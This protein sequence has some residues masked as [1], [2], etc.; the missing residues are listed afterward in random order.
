VAGLDKIFQ[1]FVDFSNSSLSKQWPLVF[2]GGFFTF[3]ALN[4]LVKKIVVLISFGFFFYSSFSQKGE[5]NK[6][7]Q[8]YNENFVSLSGPSEKILSSI[9]FESVIVFDKRFDSVS[10]GF[11]KDN[12][13]LHRG[14]L[15]IKNGLAYA[16]QKFYSGL[17]D[18][19]EETGIELVCFV[20]KTFLSDFIYV[21]LNEDARLGSKK[22]DK[23]EFSGAVARLEFY[24]K[25]DKKYYPLYRFDSTI[26][27]VKKISKEGNE[28]LSSMFA[29]AARKLSTI[30]WEKIRSTG[31]ALNSE[32]VFSHYDA[33][34]AIPVL[35]EQPVKGVY[36]SYEQF[37][38]NKPGISSFTF[39]KT[40][41][42]DF[43]YIKNRKGEDSLCLDFWGFS[44]GKDLYIYSAGNFFLLERQRNSFSF[45]GAKE[46]SA[47][48][49]LRLNAGLFNLMTPNS[50]YS[51]Q[52]TYNSYKLVKNYFLLDMDNGEFY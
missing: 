20:K 43:L 14:E 34:A 32:A 50:A 45:F 5:S 4:K 11:A 6:E 33:R 7:L 47:Q 23:E 35:Q 13:R 48:R 40:D 28:Y 10:F 42:G 21:D 3:I 15:R 37:K 39:D 30:N 1:R 16:L 38:E 17:I 9:P 25:Q 44:D 2:T 18:I 22:A 41:K 27:G 19:R 29:A 12:Q 52:Q 36:L 49:N 51:K 31:R 8:L 46:L 26:T 24:A